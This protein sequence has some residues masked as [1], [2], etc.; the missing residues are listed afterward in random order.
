MFFYYKQRDANAQRS[1]MQAHVSHVDA[2]SL[3]WT[4]TVSFR[5]GGVS[6]RETCGCQVANVAIRVVL[7]TL[8]RIRSLPI[9]HD[10]LDKHGAI[11][12]GNLILRAS[13]LTKL[14]YRGL[15]AVHVH[16]HA[17]ALSPQRQHHA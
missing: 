6:A 7:S 8:E 13:K 1:K 11:V 4:Y 17:V 12:A 5:D 10:K 9:Q 15:L 14:A 2:A 16:V 3:S